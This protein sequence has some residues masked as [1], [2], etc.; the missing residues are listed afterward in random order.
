MSGGILLVG[1]GALLGGLDELIA[2]ITQVKVHVADNPLDA[3]ITGAGAAIDAEWDL[4][5]VFSSD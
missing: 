2:S 3:V 5:A 4:G 1:G